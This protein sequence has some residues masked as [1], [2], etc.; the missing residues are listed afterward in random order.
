M[1][2]L[3]NALEELSIEYDDIKI[4]KLSMFSE[5]I[6]KSSKK[7]NL[8]GLKTREEIRD[9]LFIRSLRYAHIINSKYSAL[10]LLENKALKILDI[11]TGAGI[12][13]IPIKIFYP[14]I[15]LFLCES[16]KK[17]CEF[18]SDTI[19]K[20]DLKNIEINNQRAEVLGQSELRE[21]FDLILT[22]ALAKLPTLAEL[23]IPL[24]KIGGIVV[25]AKGNYPSKEIKDSR[26]IIR[27]LGISKNISETIEI[28]P[29]LPKDNFIIWEKMNNS[30]KIYPRRDGMPKKNP[31]IQE[32]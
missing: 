13:S 21:S 11:G 29:F 7:F 3:R 17:K 18:L 5:E 32:Q 24:L 28:P 26:Y 10:N 6:L 8:T 19:E 16:S 14:E 15:N 23:T 20:L 25:T 31:I 30:P 27:I 12:P 1:N 22:R 2:T 4:E 9:T